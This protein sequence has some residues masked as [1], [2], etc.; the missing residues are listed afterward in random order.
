MWIAFAV[1]TIL[2]SISMCIFALYCGVVIRKYNIQSNINLRI[3]VI[4]DLHSTRH[5]NLIRKIEQVNPDII[6]MPGD[7]VDDLRPVKHVTKF[8]D[9]LSKLNIP[10]YYVTGNH[11]MAIENLPDIKKQLN[12]YNVEVLDNNYKIVHIKGCKL[13]IGGLE[14]PTGLNLDDWRM[15]VKHIF[16]NYKNFDGYKILISHRPEQ[17]QLYQ[18][19]GADLAI[20][21]HAHGGQ[22]RIPFIL[23]GLFA[24]DQGFFPKY[25]GGVYKHGTMFHA[26][27]RGLSVFWNLPRIFNPP[28]IVQIDISNESR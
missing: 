15:T 12:S 14:N 8:F 16:L 17:W 13:I 9:E 26:V 23:N 10:T 20:S 19:V 1:I 18:D 11:E 5:K 21:G 3:A 24:P 25:A 7:I 28:E 2:I 4:S 6:M 22:L 27:S